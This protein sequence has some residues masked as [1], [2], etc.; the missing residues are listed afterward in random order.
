[1]PQNFL[2]EIINARPQATRYATRPTQRNRQ[3]HKTPNI[4]IQKTYRKESQICQKS[5]TK[6]FCLNVT[7]PSHK[8]HKYATRPTHMN[9]KYATRITN[10]NSKYTKRNY[11][12]PQDHLI[13]TL[14][15]RPQD[16][17]YATRP[18]QRNQKY[19]MLQDLLNKILEI[20]NQ[21]PYMPIQKIYP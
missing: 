12:M 4:P 6:N 9:P 3:C 10:R 21:T 2:L 15:I 19:H 5:C 11:N 17:K 14:N 20:C 16:T 8:N 1:M 18:T 7:I 13:K